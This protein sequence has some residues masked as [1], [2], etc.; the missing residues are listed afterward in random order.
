MTAAAKATAQKLQLLTK[1]SRNGQAE[2]NF[3]V[4]AG[5][6]DAG[7]PLR[8]KA[9][10]S[11]RYELRD[12]KTERAPEKVRAKR[13]GRDLEIFFEG[14]EKAD[15]VIEQYYDE[16]IVEFPQDSLTGITG[17]GDLATYA[18]A[19]TISDPPVLTQS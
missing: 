2:Q 9:Q 4:T 13:V 6:G 18:S 3:N 16:A 8:V 11:T 19:L 15:I 17:K 1:T 12:P 14:S 5:D 10:S 7:T